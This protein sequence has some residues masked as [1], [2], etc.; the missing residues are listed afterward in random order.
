MIAA[1][2]VAR[3]LGLPPPN[4]GAARKTLRRADRFQAALWQV[5]EAPPLPAQCWPMTPSCAAARK[6]GRT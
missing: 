3:D 2:A 5:F 1:A 4:V 6:Y